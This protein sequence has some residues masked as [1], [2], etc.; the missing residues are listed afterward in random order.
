MWLG[1]KKVV[2]AR[3]C[4]GGDS[5]YVTVFDKSVSEATRQSYHES[6]DLALVCVKNPDVFVGE[7]AVVGTSVVKDGDTVTIA[8]WGD[9]ESND[10]PT[11]GL[12]KIVVVDAEWFDV[13][14]ATQLPCSGDSGGPAYREGTKE[15]V[16]IFYDVLPEGAVCAETQTGR[17]VRVDSGPGRRWIESLACP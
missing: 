1:G 12:S 8:G 17:F 16:G 2:T 7:P 11:H 15:L 10:N 3:H 9:T 5:G 4:L 6:L 14:P 13:A